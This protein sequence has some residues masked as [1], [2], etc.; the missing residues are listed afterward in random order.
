MKKKLCLLL[1]IFC[2]IVV[3]AQNIYIGQNL[4]KERKY[5]SQN[6]QYYL[7]FQNDGNLVMYNK[8]NTAV[9]DS[10]TENKGNRAEFQKDGNFVI[11]NNSGL[12]IFTTNTYKKGNSLA[13]QNDGNLVIYDGRNNAVWASKDTKANQSGNYNTGVVYKDKTIE[14]STKIYSGNGEYFLTFQNDG[15]LVLYY[16]NS[17]SPI[18]ASNTVG[19]GTRAIFQSDG[20]LVVYNISNQAVFSSNTNNKK[21][22]KLTVQDDG[23]LVIYDVYDN[24][25]W[26]IK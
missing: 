10:K 18:W 11:Y 22:E 15:N 9:W 24:P 1:S 14:K 7:V 2:A 13:V 25:L 26:A 6:R 21:A 3:F 17:S 23:N 4:S 12:A 20:N 5:Y 19:K 8:G 16:K